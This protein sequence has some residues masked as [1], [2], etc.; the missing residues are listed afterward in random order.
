MK[1][2][3]HLSL[4]FL[5]LS[6]LASSSIHAQSVGGANAFLFRPVGIRALSL[7]GSTVADPADP[8]GIYW[9]PASLGSF[10]TFQAATVVSILPFDQRQ[11]FVGVSVPAAKW[12]TV[13][14]G[15]INYS[16]GQ[17]DKRNDY[18]DPLG[19]FTSADNAFLL[20]FGSAFPQAFGPNSSF[21]IG[22]TGK[23]VASKI[24]TRSANGGGLDAGLRVAVGRFS[25]GA[26]AQ[27][28]GLSLK[29]DTES[30]ENDKVPV[31]IRA[32]AGY[33][34]S[35]TNNRVLYGLKLGVEAEKL[36]DM[37]L[38]WLGGAEGRIVMPNPKTSLYLRAGYG[39]DVWTGGL[40][41]EI[42]LDKNTVVGLDYGASQDY[43]S[44]TLL[45]HLGLHLIL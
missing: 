7:G 19:N 3:M 34:F 6:L 8:S 33:D 2:T 15:W 36:G 9:N 41:I 45:H 30:G 24:D 18:G 42:S 17:I 21:A 31:A 12:L 43:L 40:S 20:G 38:G 10:S 29:W 26:A 23:Y 39:R 44:Q 22:L 32:G 35:V 16:V 28:I 27:N 25:L 1:T 14:G 37:T 4:A 5:A 11:N 13:G